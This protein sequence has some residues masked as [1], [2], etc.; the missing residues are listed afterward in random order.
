MIRY[1]LLLYNNIKIKYKLDFNSIL[2]IF[3][4]LT[5]QYLKIITA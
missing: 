4:S 3:L 2:I 1:T 5:E